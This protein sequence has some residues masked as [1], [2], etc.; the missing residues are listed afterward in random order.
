MGNSRNIDKQVYMWS[1][2][3]HAHQVKMVVNQVKR[4]YKD[5]V[6]ER[7]NTNDDR[8]RYHE[9]SVV[10]VLLKLDSGLGH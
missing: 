7:L 5:L 1:Y 9:R 6:I 10:G 2:I 3:D 8:C 4:R